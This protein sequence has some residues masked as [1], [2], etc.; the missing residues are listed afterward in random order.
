MFVKHSIRI[1]VAGRF[2]LSY[3]E[4]GVC[5]MVRIDLP[6]KSGFRIEEAEVFSHIQSLQTLGG[7]G[8]VPFIIIPINRI[9]DITVLQICVGTQAAGQLELAFK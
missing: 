7:S 1:I 3:R 6:E 8:E 9:T 4:R 5:A 2:F